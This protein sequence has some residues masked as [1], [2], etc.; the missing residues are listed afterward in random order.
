MQF[1][2][3]LSEDQREAIENL[4]IGIADSLRVFPETEVREYIKDKIGK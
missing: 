1:A 4:Q 2:N 3:N